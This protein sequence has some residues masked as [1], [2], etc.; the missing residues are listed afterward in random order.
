MPI[1]TANQRVAPRIMRV[2]ATEVP[3]GIFASTKSPVSEVSVAARPPGKNETAPMTVEK[4]Y[5][6]LAESILKW[7]SRPWRTK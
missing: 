6:K 3:L 2:A 5:M 1:I 7:T 4:L